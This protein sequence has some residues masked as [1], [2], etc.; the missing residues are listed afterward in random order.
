MYLRITDDTLRELSPQIVIVNAYGPTECTIT[1]CAKRL[2][3]SY[4]ITIGG[5][6][7]NTKIYVLDAFGN[8]LPPY[9]VGELVITGES[10]G[11]GYMNLPEKTAASFFRLRGMPAY[12][13][14]DLVRLNTAG[15]VEFFGRRD[16]QVKLRGFRIELNEIEKCIFRAAPGGCLLQK[17]EGVER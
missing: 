1:C 4:N 16:N 9:A 2:E 17:G 13:S 7:N 8:I 6:I 3:S 15:E 10:V 5:P 14:G 12:H 11:R